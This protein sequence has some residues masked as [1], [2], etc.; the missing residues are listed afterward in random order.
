M[1]SKFFSFFYFYQWWKN[2]DKF[3][4]SIVITLFITGLFFSLVSTSL[5]ASDKLNTNSYFFFFKHLIFVILGLLIIF[6][7]S[8]LDQDSLF[9]ISIY[10]FFFSLILLI[11]VPL[12][13]VNVKG[14][15]RWLDLFILP[16]IQPI[17]F[18]K[19]FFIIIMGLIISNNQISSFTL[20]FFVTFLITSS[21]AILLI[22]QPDLGQTLLIVISWILLIFIS[23][24]SLLTL[25]LLSIAGLSFLLYLV[26]YVPKFLYIKNR[27]FSFFDKETGSY[28]FQS[29]K[30]MFEIEIIGNRML[31]NVKGKPTFIE[32]I[33]EIQKMNRQN[34]YEDYLF[35]KG[36]SDLTELV[37]IQL[38]EAAPSSRAGK[39]KNFLSGFL[40]MQK[41]LLS[42]P[43]LKK[44][45]SEELMIDVKTNEL[46]NSILYNFPNCYQFDTR[47]WGL[48]ENFKKLD[49]SE[50]QIFATAAIEY[51]RKR[52][53]KKIASKTI[54]HSIT[55][56]DLQIDSSILASLNHF[57]L[58]WALAKH[59]HQDPKLQNLGRL[60]WVYGQN[61]KSSSSTMKSLIEEFLTDSGEPMSTS[62]IKEYILTKRS[63]AGNFQI[64]PSTSMGDI[65]P[66]A[67]G[68]WGLAFRDLAITRD[69]EQQ[70]LR[71][72]KNEFKQGNF[73]INEAKL[74]MIMQAIPLDKSLSLFQI[75]RLLSRHAS[76]NPSKKRDDFHVKTHVKHLNKCFV[77]STESD[78]EWSSLEF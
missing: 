58:N 59:M 54:F 25:S 11:L 72:L 7:L 24:I 20:K 13:G 14:S 53:D 55:T 30:A 76:S 65:I 47:A 52:P 45:A 60:Y 41:T 34:T 56:T 2:L 22:I 29:D 42:T 35:F 18:V 9:R 57:D 26:F 38:Q 6:I 28:N 10:I 61:H 69:Q 78:V 32:C 19:P 39:V 63:I 51:L 44:A 37:K 74:S 36:R 40:P 1:I 46:L 50:A 16:R 62:H 33:N 70:L 75:S 31:F 21:I 68:V 77:V 71:Q 27:I 64:R 67:P 12:I 73:V 5:I 43:A 49:S 15:K 66:T 8:Y 3:I 48:E 17:E 23:G 4:L